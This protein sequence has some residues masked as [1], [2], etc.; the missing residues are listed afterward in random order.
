MTGNAELAKT[1]KIEADGIDGYVDRATNREIHGWI[2]NRKDPAARRVVNVYVDDKLVESFIACRFRQ[3]LKEAKIG[4][5]FYSFE[6][7]LPQAKVKPSSV[8]RLTDAATGK[9]FRGSPIQ[10]RAAGTE[11]AASE[12]PTPGRSPR[13]EPP[14]D[15]PAAKLAPGKSAAEPAPIL[16]PAPMQEREPAPESFVQKNVLAMP[17][18]REFVETSRIVPGK[19]RLIGEVLR[20]DWHGVVGWVADLA[21]PMRKLEV[22]VQ[23][24]GRG[25]GCACAD[26]PPPVEQARNIGDGKHGFRLEFKP[27]HLIAEG[28]RIAV[29]ADGSD[30]ALPARP[31]TIASAVEGGLDRCDDR[32]VRGWAID[33]HDLSRKLT[34]EIYINE[35]L[36]GEVVAERFRNDLKRLG[37]GDGA[38]GFL[39]KY[40]QQIEMKLSSDVAVRA[41]IARTDVELKHSPWWV[42][43]AVKLQKQAAEA[44]S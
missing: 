21:D 30:V 10:L 18:K 26:G 37:A 11:A 4:D 31:A 44:P 15:K 8:L 27:E 1:P 24:D 19:S 13:L 38:C 3:D 34:V 39:F 28:M 23:V 41:V 29:L 25:C 36:V 14:G 9:E 16:E 2:W 7:A 32:L 6:I 40:P 43:R 33:W 35:T 22:Q 5:G 12:K 17:A 20:A 42:G